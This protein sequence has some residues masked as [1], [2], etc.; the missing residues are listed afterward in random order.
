[1]LCKLL[2]H[3]LQNFHG[4][5]LDADTASDA[6]GSRGFGLHD[7]DLHGA[8]RYA[9]AAA[10]AELLV[11]HVHAGLGILGDGA[12]LTAAGALA[13]LDADHGLCTGALGHDLDAAQILVEFL[14]ESGGTGTDALQA[15]HALDIFLN[16]QLLHNKSYPFS[17]LFIVYYTGTK[18]K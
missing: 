5:G 14:I 13:A 17:F 9:L 2:F 10:D 3:D 8:G 12:V 11:D 15:C 7:H 4:A 1:M 6:L 18:Q 16:S